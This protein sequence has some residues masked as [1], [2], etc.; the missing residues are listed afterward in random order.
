MKVSFGKAVWQCTLRLFKIYVKNL[1]TNRNEKLLLHSFTFLYS[2]V[3]LSEL[4]W[5][6]LWLNFSHCLHIHMYTYIR[7]Y[8]C[9]VFLYKDNALFQ[10]FYP[11]VYGMVKGGVFL[12]ILHMHPGFE[13]IY[14][15]NGF[16]FSCSLLLLFSWEVLGYLSLSGTIWVYSL[17]HF[18]FTGYIVFHLGSIL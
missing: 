1:K 17:P 9:N 8:I 2:T 18:S 3:Q 10:I 16:F 5:A 4:E 15:L 7:M 12:Y 6:V 14:L 11:L 13:K